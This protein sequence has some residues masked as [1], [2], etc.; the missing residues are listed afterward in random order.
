ME[1]GIHRHGIRN[2]Q[3]GVRNPRL[4]WITLH[5]EKFGL[6]KKANDS[7]NDRVGVKAKFF[8]GVVLLEGSQWG[9]PQP[10]KGSKLDS[11]Q[12]AAQYQPS[13]YEFE[14]V[15]GRSRATQS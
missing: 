9:L 11:C 8:L 6:Q 12:K 7:H 3:R 5:G 10:S 1:S 13:N 14:G 4:S 15:L 2:L